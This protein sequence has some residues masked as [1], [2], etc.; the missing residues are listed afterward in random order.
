MHL[1]LSRSLLV[2]VFLAATAWSADEAP[3]PSMKDIL[4][5]RIAETVDSCL[6][7]RACEVLELIATTEAKSVLST[8]AEAPAKSLL[9]KEAKETLRRMQRT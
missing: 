9:A 3:K 2:P 5:A 4:K 8:W 7:A 6:A 1:R